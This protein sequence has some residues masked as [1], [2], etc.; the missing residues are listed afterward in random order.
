M[1]DP[2][3]DVASSMAHSSSPNATGVS[4]TAVVGWHGIPAWGRHVH[5]EEGHDAAST[6]ARHGT[7]RRGSAQNVAEESKSQ[8]AAQSAGS[9]QTMSLVGEQD[10]S[11]NIPVPHDSEHGEH[12]RSVVRVGRR[13]WYCPSEHDART[14]EHTRSEVS[15]SCRDWNCPPVQS[16]AGPQTASEVYVAGKA[17]YSPT[18]QLRTLRQILSLVGLQGVVSKV[19][20]GHTVQLAQTVF[21][22]CVQLAV[23]QVRAGHT[24]QGVHSVLDEVLQGRLRNV[25]V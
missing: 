24:T 7:P 20:S 3:H 13:A 9:R 8:R 14:A 15:V 19:P 12:T 2:E 5:R 11:R 6:N 22:V 16:V 23:F 21:V 4:S 10:V 25:V 1:Q 17:R 18:R